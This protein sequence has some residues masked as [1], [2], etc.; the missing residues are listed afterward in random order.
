M[1]FVL[2]FVGGVLAVVSGYFWLKDSRYG[3]GDEVGV[4]VPKGYDPRVVVEELGF[5][6]GTSSS[7]T[8]GGEKGMVVVETGLE[9]QSSSSF[10]GESIEKEVV[11]VEARRS[12]A[13]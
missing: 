2:L 11:I 3:D 6:S 4:I 8:D 10:E 9:S 13:L 7:F 12:E 1:Y 5:E